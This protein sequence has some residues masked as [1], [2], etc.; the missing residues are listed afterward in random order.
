MS[1][2]LSKR[3]LPHLVLERHRIAE[4]WRSERWD[5]LRFQ[6]PNSEVW[7]CEY[8]F[9]YTDPDA[10]AS[11]S[12]IADFIAAFAVS[13]AAPVRCG[14]TATTLRRRDGGAGFRVETSEGPIE[15]ANVVVAAGPYQR[16]VI[17]NLLP[18]DADIFQ[19]HSGAYRNP[20]Q[21]P[22]GAVLVIGS[23]NSGAQI[24]DELLRAGR[25]VYLSVSRHRRLARRYRGHTYRWWWERM[26]T[27]K[28]PVEKRGPDQ[29]PS[30]ITGAYGGY[31][32]DFR[33][34][35]ARGMTL[36]G[37]AEVMRDGVMSF[38]PDLVNNLAHGDAAY[39]SYLDAADA[40]ANTA[41]LDLPE[42]PDARVVEPDP[43]CV[44]EPIRHLN[45]RDAG[46][47]T[48]IWATGYALDLS[49]ID[50][51]VFDERGAPVHRR[52]VS[53]IPGLYF[54]GLQWLSRM[55]SG[56]IYGVGHDADYLAD[57]IA[58]NSSCPE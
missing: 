39:A 47:A 12:D 24:A 26:G 44:V 53:N 49:W 42:Q 43:H 16:P 6:S 35:A 32:I 54:L 45:L 46:I 11:A 9:P 7:L 58:A 13:I 56:F 23:G 17:P 18:P 3:D 40:Y 19:V 8:P 22:I 28:T 20:G 48:V 5:S 52:G 21:L 31:T 14:V 50:I 4:R 15:A 1:A 10:F 57:H 29:S 41:S 36:L 30:V 37:R 27:L 34:F 33:R 38:A 51:P 25:R 55:E 2:Q